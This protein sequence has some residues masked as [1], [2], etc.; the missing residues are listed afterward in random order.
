MR[1]AVAP[2]WPYRPCTTTLSGSREQHAGSLRVV[3]FPKSS[4][5][6][7]PFVRGSYETNFVKLE[8]N[9]KNICW[10]KLRLERPNAERFVVPGR[11]IRG[12]K[13]AG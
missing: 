2:T 5:A 3:S 4:R 11:F 10:N 9:A 13:P 1:P 7:A 6:H 12:G 8:G